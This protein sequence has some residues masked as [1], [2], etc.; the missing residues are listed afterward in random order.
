MSERIGG[1][2]PRRPKPGKV[3][4]AAAGAGELLAVVGHGAMRTAAAMVQSR[5]PGALAKQVADQMAAI[6]E[7][8]CATVRDVLAFRDVGPDDAEPPA[9]WVAQFGQLEANKR[10]QLAKLGWQAARASPLGVE[11]ARQMAVAVA[12]D[13]TD[14]ERQVPALNV[15]IQ[16]VMTPQVFP[17]LLLDEHGD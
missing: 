5:Q 8:S 1:R 2:R 14:A 7:Q 4:Q 3:Q 10:L 9:Q 17:D 13:R 16:M 11:V 15:A 12:R 6:T